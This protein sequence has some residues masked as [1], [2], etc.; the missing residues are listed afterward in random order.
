MIVPIQHL[1]YKKIGQ[2]ADE[3][4][5]NYHPS[6]S[7]P[8]PIEEIAEQKLK[9]KIT[10]IAN[11]KKD[12][13]VDGFLTSDLTT[14]FIDL[15]MY[16]NFESRTRSTIAH[17]IGHLILHKEVFQK[18]NINSVEKLN[19]ISTELTNEEYGW[20]EY[21]AYSFASQVLVPTKALFNALE[22]RL[23][24]IPVQETPEVLAAAIQDLPD[25]FQVSDAVILRRL[26]KAGVVKNSS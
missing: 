19:Y 11:L 22:K 18:L 20:L 10:Q 9:L 15:N 24:R 23:G 25:I 21:Q 6:L 13:D 12:Y 1:S 26:Q 7:L 4:L 17:E 8:I 5:N 3:F 2:I 16:L 14:I